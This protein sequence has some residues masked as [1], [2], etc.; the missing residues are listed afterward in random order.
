VLDENRHRS[1]RGPV[2]VL[3]R[4][5]DEAD[6]SED[7]PVDGDVGDL[8]A[9]VRAYPAS[10]RSGEALLMRADNSSRVGSS[11]G[12]RSGTIRPSSRPEKY[13]SPSS[14]G[15]R[16]LAEHAAVL[17]Q[18]PQDGRLEARAEPGDRGRGGDDVVRA[19]AAPR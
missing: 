5:V 15:Y 11:P 10:A 8:Q 17:H 18:S 9:V 2:D 6:G 3:R 12:G 4:P 13:G 1:R 7:D 14:S 19:A 16:A